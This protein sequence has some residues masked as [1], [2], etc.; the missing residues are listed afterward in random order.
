MLRFHPQSIKIFNIIKNKKSLG[1]IYN[2]SINV[3][4]YMPNWHKYENYKDLYASNKNLGGGVILTECHEIDL[5][6][7]ILKT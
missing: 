1:T 5:M 3:N 7:F 4:S 2:A 6:N